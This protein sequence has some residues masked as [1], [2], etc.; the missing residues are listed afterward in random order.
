[1]TTISPTLTDQRATPPVKQAT[2]P[3]RQKRRSLAQS[4]IG[5][6]ILGLVGIAGALILWEM[7]SVTGLLS[8]SAV[9]PASAALI[10]FFHQLTNPLFWE[11]LWNTLSI[12]LI[13]LAL[14]I[15][16]ATPLALLIGLSRFAAESTWFL[17]EFLKPIPPIAL[18]PLGLLLWGP[19]PGMKLFLITLGAVW[20]L[21]TQLV[22]GIRQIDGVASNM[23]RS[24]RLGW[25]LT[26][27]R[28]VIPSILPFAMTGLRISAAI[29]VI[30][31]V[32]TEMIGGAAGL[33]QLIVVAQSAGALEQM[34][35]L[36]LAAGLL[37]LGINACFKA[38]ER[39]LLFW[40]AS[41]R[42]D[43]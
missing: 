38:A 18:I 12:V 14:I 42:E 43:S 30:I 24:Y 16:V 35:A 13:G 25:K 41:V 7:L 5:R 37:G 3:Q 27:T 1:M 4:S 2:L 29:A 23:A 20:P 15:V 21:L 39:P 8:V 32:V 26:T 9:P 34:Y 33:G 22:Y 19:S 6:N 28:V 31:A 17:I 36:I 11:A 40:H 10:E